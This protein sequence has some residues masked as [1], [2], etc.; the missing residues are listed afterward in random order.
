MVG[1]RSALFL[2]VISAT[3][4][5]SQTF[6]IL[7]ETTGKRAF[8][9]ID[10]TVELRYTVRLTGTSGSLAGVLPE[11]IPPACALQA[12]QPIFNTTYMG[13]VGGNSTDLAVPTWANNQTQTLIFRVHLYNNSVTCGGTGGCSGNNFPFQLRFTRTGTTN[14]ISAGDPSNWLGLTG[15][16]GDG[17]KV[18]AVVSET[19]P[20]VC[21]FYVTSIFPSVVFTTIPALLK[22]DP[23]VRVFLGVDWNLQVNNNPNPNIT[24]ENGLT[25]FLYPTGPNQNDF[26]RL[27][28]GNVN[29]GGALAPFVPQST[30]ILDQNNQAFPMGPL[31]GN[32]PF[33]STNDCIQHT[34]NFFDITDKRPE[35]QAA[36]PIINHLSNP[37]NG[38]QENTVRM[39]PASN[40]ATLRKAGIYLV[41]PSGCDVGNAFGTPPTQVQFETYN[42]LPNNLVEVKLSLPAAWTTSGG[43]QLRSNYTVEWFYRNQGTLKKATLPGGGQTPARSLATNLEI[44]FV[45][46][47]DYVLEARIRQTGSN[48]IISLRSPGHALSY[49]QLNN[50]SFEN[51]EFD[52]NSLVHAADAFFDPGETLVQP[53]RIQNLGGFADDVTITLGRISPLTSEIAYFSREGTTV[54]AGTGNSQQVF[55]RDLPASASINMDVLYELL[56]LD[57]ACRDMDLFFEVSYRH[58]GM[59]TKFRREFRVQGF[60][61]L[62]QNAYELSSSWIASQHAGSPPC[63]GSNCVGSG[64]SSQT[65]TSGWGFA[66]DQWVGA[67][68][69]N[70]FFYTLRSSDIGFPIGAKPRIVLAHQ[71]TFPFQDAGGIVEY[72]TS[73]ISGPWSSWNDLIQPLEAENGL[74]LY[75]SNSFTST[76]AGRDN[77][78]GG[79]KVFMNMGTTQ[80]FDLSLSKASLTGHRVQ[81]RFLYHH[82]RPSSGSPGLWRIEDFAY[83]TEVEQF[84]DVFGLGRNLVFNSCIPTIQLIPKIAGNYTYAWYT[85]FRNLIEDSPHAITN[86]GRWDFPVPGSA[87]DYYVKVTLNG[88]GTTRYF[89]MRI[90]AAASVP[91]F[92]QIVADWHSPGAFASSDIN[93]DGTVDVRDGVLQMILDACK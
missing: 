76:A 91:S 84:D 59:A 83:L 8:D 93:L 80:S 45:N 41:K 51:A 29:G 4:G 66:G 61:D 74:N 34:W 63:N 57:D 13:Y 85:D 46:P 47:S 44:P 33:Q 26:F 25:S 17:Y 15:P 50:R 7:S 23:A 81:F 21:G 22:D 55:Q 38:L 16:E 48:A 49:A 12:G 53:M 18:V 69:A 60:C 37:R 43:T 11:L 82:V 64:V 92:A 65:P 78:L 3:L 67:A 31:G 56:Q 2:L 35:S 39:N 52:P 62:A 90:D 73:S 75:N 54:F 88:P 10:G 71:A 89:K 36:P 30:L 14:V 86:I 79:R 70:T 27:K 9:Q 58:Q 20:S 42:L 87:T 1:C 40:G 72:R 19:L 32:G 68:S 5:M 77:V 6:T 24:F 28:E